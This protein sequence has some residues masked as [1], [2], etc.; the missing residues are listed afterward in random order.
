MQSHKKRNPY[1]LDV[2]QDKKVQTTCDLKFAAWNVRA[3]LDR[4][5]AERPER[6]SA[7]I[8]R[9]LAKYSVDIGA[10]S[11]VRFGGTGSIREEAGYTI[12]WSGK[13]SGN[14]SE[15]GVALAISNAIASKLTEDPKPVSDRMITLRLPLSN[16][17]Y[18]TIISV[19]APTMTNHPDNISQFYN[20]LDAVLKGVPKEDKILLLGDFNARVGQ[21]DSTWNKVLGQFG[22]GKSNSNGELLLSICTEHQLVITNTCF[23]H[24]PAHKHSWMHPRS[25]HWHLIDFIITRQRDLCDFHD[26]RAMRGA[27]CSTDHIMILAKTRL[28]VR[29]PMRKTNQRRRKLNIDKIQ[30]DTIRKELEEK[31]QEKLPSLSGSVEEKWSTFRSTIWEVSEST[32]GYAEKKCADWF[33]E[34][35]DELSRLFEERNQARIEML[36]R[37]TRSIRAKYKNSSRLLQKR[38][39]ELKNQ[40]WQSK[41]A[42]LQELADMNDIR[43]FHQGLKA[44]WGPRTSYPDQ[45]LASDNQ[46]LLTEK[47]DLLAR[48]TEHFNT[49]LNE[50]N[51]VDQ[52]VTD[53]I[54]QQPLQSWMDEVPSV[55]EV[56]D[57]I[58]LLSNRKSPG[59][60]GIHP[61]I[62]KF[63]GQV[64]VQRLHE[65]IVD[66]WE[67][68]SPP[69]DWKDAQLITLFKKGDRRLCG[70]YRGISL[71]SIPG[72]V[73][74]RILL[75]RLGSYAE[76]LL[77]EAQCGFRA[78]RGTIDMIFSLKQIQEKCI[79][80]RMPLYMV[81][82]DFTKAFDTVNREA[83]WIILRKFGCPA[84]FTEL[85]S[86]L[87]TGM[88]AS[89]SMKGDMSDY[90]VV[91]NGVKQG[92]VLAPIL[93]S[94][95]LTAVLNHAFRDSQKGVWIQSRPGADL[96]NVN[97]FKSTRSTTK[98]LVREL[99]FAD[100][101]AFIAHTHSDAQEIISLFATSAH[102]FGLKVNIKK[103]EVMYQ[104]PPGLLETGENIHIDGEDLALVDKFK[105]LGS[106]ISKDN[107]LDNELEIRISNA[108]RSFGRLRERVWNN[109]DLTIKTKCA[110]YRA[111]VLSTLLYG[112]ESWVVYRATA[113][114]LSAYMMGHL[115]RILNIKWWQF[116]SNDKILQRT[117]LPSMYDILRNRC[118]RWAGHVNRQNNTR[119]PKLILYSQLKEGTR[120]IGRPKLR[121]KDTIKRNLNDRDISLGSWQKL[122]RDRENWR[123]LIR[124]RNTSSSAT[125]DS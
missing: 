46:T 13:T 15:S 2:A 5:R 72:K 68:R 57:A 34:N 120:G 69:Q 81:F 115:R 31:I 118:L 55:K 95:Y 59:A 108:S 40:W 74:A 97:Q 92:C 10:L 25:K 53:S 3:M 103:T 109:K 42:E 78:G 52:A 38:C 100:D 83:L 101:T 65:I 70:N 16:S 90:F 4:E 58:S 80:Q 87:H 14:Q 77:P 62:I 71:L 107:K 102:Q 99:M 23:Q 66:S 47:K 112:V 84:H 117:S 63:G 93:F 9:E 96:F 116:V 113:H 86:A 110:V 75:N 105:Y 37:N 44:V 7:I 48:W 33:D 104:P 122:S 20:Q 73:F 82:V 61:E 26:T 50:K 123:Q 85:V 22:T 88:K 21:D 54:E 28:R 39:R 114:K 41:A 106:T 76:G 51:E 64:L 35:D 45:L 119:L 124:R 29:K 19:Y 49:L 27:N 17:R 89:V 111:I 79:E 18:C 60:D 91:D 8:A 36:N 56:E 121:Y 98:V 30:S 24:K 11:E 94:I 43:G 125:M 12:F 1:W 67:N 32:L 6:R